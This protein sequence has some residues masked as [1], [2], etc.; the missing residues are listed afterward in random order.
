MELAELPGIQTRQAPLLQTLREYCQKSRKQRAVGRM[1]TSIIFI[2]SITGIGSRK[3]LKNPFRPFFMDAAVFNEE[4]AHY[5]KCQRNIQVLCRRLYAKDT[6]HIGNSQIN[7]YCHHIRDIPISVLSQ[8]SPEKVSQSADSRFQKKLFF[9]RDFQ[10][11]DS[12]PESATILP[13]LPWS[14][15]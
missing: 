3:L 11:S 7:N 12:L 14:P 9:F 4:H 13:A 15:R 6:W 1:R 5:C 10:L 2:G 8:D